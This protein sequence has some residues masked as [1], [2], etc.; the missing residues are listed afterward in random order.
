MSDP[1]CCRVPSR[2]NDDRQLQ[3]F[4]SF[5][6]GHNSWC[7][8][9]LCF[10][11]NPPPQ[12]GRLSFLLPDAEQQQ[13]LVVALLSVTLYFVHNQFANAWEWLGG[14]VRQQ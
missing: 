7:E 11:T 4:R 12:C 5:G 8:K 2:G 1:T 6:Q 14:V 9:R 3:R 13:T 10:S